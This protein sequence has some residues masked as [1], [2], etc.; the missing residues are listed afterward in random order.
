MPGLWKLDLRKLRV[1]IG[2]GCGDHI[3]K[4]GQFDLLLCGH[5]HG[6]QIRLPRYGAMT[7]S[8]RLG[9]RYEAGLYGL[10]S[11]RHLYVSRGVG[12]GHVWIR[13]LCPPE[14]ALLTLRSLRG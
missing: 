9:K 6:G 3:G 11:G 2:I 10:G 8:T 12:E 1:V 4:D 14:L 13:I 7:T 5:T